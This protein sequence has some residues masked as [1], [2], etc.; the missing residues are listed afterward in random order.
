MLIWLNASHSTSTSCGHG[1]RLDVTWHHVIE[2]NVNLAKQVWAAWGMAIMCMWLGLVDQLGCTMTIVVGTGLTDYIWAYETGPWLCQHTVGSGWL[3]HYYNQYE[4]P[5]LR[6]FFFDV[7]GSKACT[8]IACF[9][10]CYILFSIS[11]YPMDYVIF[12]NAWTHWS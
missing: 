3:F 2:F 11:D 7:M 1:W 6:S 12:L 9:M 8:S 5:N 4:L 10:W